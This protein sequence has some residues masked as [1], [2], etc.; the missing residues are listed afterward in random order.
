[1]AVPP[2]GGAYTKDLILAAAAERG[3]WLAFGV[4]LAGA[5]SALYAGRLYLLAIGVRR[6]AAN[7][8]SPYWER[9]AMAALAAL[10][11]ALGVLWIPGAASAAADL[12]G[13]RLAR[14]AGWELPAS[15]L[16]IALAAAAAWGLS[17]RDALLHLGLPQKTGDRLA[18][19]LGIPTLATRLVVTPTLGAAR[20]LAAFDDR[21]VDAGVRA[22][23]GVAAGLSRLLAWWGERSADG[24]VLGVARLTLGA[25]AV[26]RAADDR[27]VDAAI[28]RTALGVRH[29]GGWARTLQSGLSH[30]YYVIAAVGTVLAILAAFL[31]R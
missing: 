14:S 22:A 6:D 27:G 18:E 19:W 12:V 16:A 28:E 26:S 17:R 2:L 13:G 11:L 3:P 23:G 29:A 21:V 24:A 15:L 30:Q 1:A 4:L 5:M 7:A 25:A 9:A 31:R 20:A 8:P 10:S